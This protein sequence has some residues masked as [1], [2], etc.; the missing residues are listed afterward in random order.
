[1][2]VC[3][4]YAEREA[5]RRCSFK[6]GKKVREIGKKV[7]AGVSGKSYREWKIACHS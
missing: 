3:K 6:E 2:I 5:G 4:E 7:C 1:M